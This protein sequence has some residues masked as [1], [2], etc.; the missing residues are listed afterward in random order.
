MCGVGDA[1]AQVQ[2]RFL[3][4]SKKRNDIDIARIMRFA[5]KGLVGGLIWS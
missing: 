2:E 4:D 3:S 5:L 1:V